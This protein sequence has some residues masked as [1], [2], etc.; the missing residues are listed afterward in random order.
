M[1]DSSLGGS[2][3]CEREREE[4]KTGCDESGS[5]PIDT[6]VCSDLGANVGRHREEGA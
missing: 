6:C 5:D 2:A 1:T 3:V 4:D